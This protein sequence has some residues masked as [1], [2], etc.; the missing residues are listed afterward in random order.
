MPKPSQY[1]ASLLFDLC[2]KI[3]QLLLWSR[4][5]VIPLISYSIL[6]VMN[7]LEYRVLQRDTLWGL[8]LPFVTQL[9][10]FQR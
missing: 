1:L 7:F 3:N 9:L 6:I 10:L 5:A 2:I 4:K 8:V